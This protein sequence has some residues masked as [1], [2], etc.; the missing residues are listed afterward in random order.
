MYVRILESYEH[1]SNQCEPSK[2]TNG[3][4]NPILHALQFQ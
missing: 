1:I 4:E 2:I 3:A